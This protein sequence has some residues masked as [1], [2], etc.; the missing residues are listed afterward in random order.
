MN[1]KAVIAGATGLV[2][3]E[4]AKL[5]LNDEIYS[6]LTLIVRRPTGVVHPKLHEKVVDF[7]KLEEIDI[8]LTEADVFCTLGTT[9]KKAGSREAFRKVDYDYPL[10]LGR[11]AKAQGAKQFLIITAIGAKIS[12]PAFYSRVKGEI[13][14]AL[15]ALKLPVLQIFRPSL[16]LGQREEFRRGEHF[17]SVVF[18]VI[19]PIFTGPLKKY[20][21]IQGR[22]VAK[23]MLAAAQREISGVCIYESNEIERLSNNEA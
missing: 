15:S 22:E 10:A 23:G 12:S 2:G 13:E 20:R 18:K 6:D 4:L 11:M 21:A 8:D 1:R 5:I 17:A 19:S 3:K 16:L 7:E 9:I 14:E